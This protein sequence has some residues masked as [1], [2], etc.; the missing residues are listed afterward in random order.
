M[1]LAKK[2]SLV[3][4]EKYFENYLEVSNK[5]LTFAH[6]FGNGAS[7]TQEEVWVSG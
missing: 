7:A 4:S 1:R 2:K 5:C 3:L 6:A